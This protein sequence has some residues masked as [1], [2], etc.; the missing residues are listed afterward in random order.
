VR[1][2]GLFLIGLAD[3]SIQFNGETTAPDEMTGETAE[4]PLQEGTTLSKLTILMR[5]G[6][7]TVLIKV[8]EDLTDPPLPEALAA[9]ITGRVRINLGKGDDHAALLLGNATLDI[10]GNLEG[11]LDNGDDCL[12]VGTTGLLTGTDAIPETLPIQVGGQVIILGRLGQDVVAL[13]GL[14]IQ[15]SVIIDGGDHAD[16]LAIK[17]CILNSSL[18]LKGGGGDDDLALDEVTVAGTSNI[19]GGSGADRLLLND[20]AA[21]KNV[22]VNLGNGNDQLEVSGTFTL[23]GTAK[24][25]LDGGAGTDDLLSEPIFT[26]PPVKQRKF[27]NTGAEASITPGDILTAIDTLIDDCLATAAP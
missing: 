9:T 19:Q 26:D 6:D 15:K 22:S 25:T 24:A 3:T 1:E 2:D 7:D 11:D 12:V 18:T 5:G 13:A 10:G 27:E 21:A 4:V 8:G 16:S 14:E 17:S 23:T 20:V